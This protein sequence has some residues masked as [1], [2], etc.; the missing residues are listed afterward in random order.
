MKQKLA[1]NYLIGLE[2]NPGVMAF[3]VLLVYHIMVEHNGYQL[4]KIQ[5]VSKKWHL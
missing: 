5:M 3:L 1:L 4:Q 2:N